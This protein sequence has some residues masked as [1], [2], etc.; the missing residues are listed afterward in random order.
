MIKFK[1]HGYGVGAEGL[2][3][4]IKLIFQELGCIESQYDIDLGAIYDGFCGFNFNEGMTDEQWD[5]LS[6]MLKVRYCAFFDTLEEIDPD[7]Y[8]VYK[9]IM[10]DAAQLLTIGHK[11]SKI[12]ITSEIDADDCWFVI[13]KYY[14]E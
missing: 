8:K 3:S 13:F 9:L 7:S 4:N 11:S 12:S 1:F 2:E 14:E 5:I 10:L 6:S